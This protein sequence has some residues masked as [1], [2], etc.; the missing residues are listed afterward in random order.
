M[1]SPSTS[2]IPKAK[3]S[4]KIDGTLVEVDEGT[5]IL[6]AAS[7]ASACS[8]ADIYIPV[9]CHVHNIG[10]V[11]HNEEGIKPVGVCRLCVVELEQQVKDRNIYK[12]KPYAAACVREL[13]ARFDQDLVVHTS[14]DGVKAARST[15]LQLL[16]VD[17]P[18]N[19][20]DQRH[21][22]ECELERLIDK[23]NV[24]ESPYRSLSSNKEASEHKD[25][26]VAIHVDHS[27][28][29]LC[30]RCVR[31][32]VVEK[33]NVIARRD[34]GHA[35]GIGFGMGN[36]MYSSG[37]VSCGACV[38]ACPT[39]AIAS[40]S[41]KEVCH[42]PQ[43]DD[44]AKCGEICTTTELLNLPF[45]IFRHVT[46]NFLDQNLGCVVR[47]H[48]K[49]DEVIF[50]E[51][52]QPS[53]TAFF[54]EKGQIE[55]F[56]KPR[57][58]AQ[59]TDS[60]IPPMGIS[61]GKLGPGELVGEMSCI[62][63]YPRLATACAATQ[64]V[65]VLEMMSNMLD[66]VRN[67]MFRSEFERKHRRRALDVLL[68]DNEV[69][70]SLKE[71]FIK[72][73]HENARLERYG[74]GETICREEESADAFYLI[75]IGF[76]RVSRTYPRGDFV[77]ARLTPGNFFGEMALLDKKE[78]KH[79]YT[80]KAVHHVDV[81]RIDAKDFEAMM[82]EHPK[83][84]ERLK[85]I[86][87]ERE[88]SNRKHLEE[89][90]RYK[91]GKVELGLEEAQSL[92]VLDLDKCTRCDQCV[93]ACEHTHNGTTRLIRDGRRVDHY[94]VASACRHCHD[95]LCMVCH[96]NAITRDEKHESRAVVI[97]PALCVGCGRCAVG[98][99]YG[100][101]KLFDSNGLVP[102]A[103]LE[104]P[105]QRTDLKAT[106]TSCDLCHDY[107]V[108]NCVFACPHDAAKRR[109]AAEFQQIREAESSRRTKKLGRR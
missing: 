41:H 40:A 106:A 37:C 20:L 109:T 94:L 103:A 4:L 63:S 42:N 3:V 71:T 53:P 74:P 47:R 51:G 80:C 77:A 48:F 100:N 7:I 59:A 92:L 107:E 29:I 44:L 39:G 85:A 5:S 86:A 105:T 43:K 18:P 14:S 11:P 66:M 95:P 21:G 8:G 73:L 27:A 15:L 30:D 24:A 89:F 96:W 52:D 54:I 62:N 10:P 26:S 97:E 83:I 81:V 84:H 101:I 82:E 13:D 98:C 104:D 33:H 88:E 58:L 19:C 2:R 61:R 45:D 34:K 36:P 31:A 75:A 6:E 69:F 99:P 102:Y 1:S 68:P 22:Q 28:C 35:A 9:L 108:P 46:V 78:K 16:M 91:P 38:L 25:S 17:H 50:N 55:V 56:T 60:S 12:G 90:S 76:V 32:C 23:L 57:N 87:K 79:H 70:T 72:R 93:I 65:V 49:K 64:E 67:S